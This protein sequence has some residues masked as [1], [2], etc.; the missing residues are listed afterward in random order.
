MCA[1]PERR[2][3]EAGLVCRVL[4]SGMGLPAS[5]AAWRDSWL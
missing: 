2:L 3:R 4:R 1:V 5:V